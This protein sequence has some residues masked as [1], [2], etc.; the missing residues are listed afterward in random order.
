MITETA[1]VY[2][3]LAEHYHLI[4][5]DWDWSIGRQVRSGRCWKAGWSEALQKYSTVPVGS[6][7]K[8]SGL[9]NAVI[10]STPLI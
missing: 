4:F 9:H 8:L 1:R 10:W 7:H 2:D 3:D 5:Q 6:E